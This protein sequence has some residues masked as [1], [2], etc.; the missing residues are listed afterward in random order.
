MPA[1]NEPASLTPDELLLWQSLGRLV[2]SLPRVLEEDMARTSV[3]MTEFAVLQLLSEA[4]GR[5]LRMSA[6][7]TAA[8]HPL[9]HHPRRRRPLRPRPGP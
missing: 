8:P 9:P 3:T 6:L 5:C 4:P 2:H 7:A 1:D